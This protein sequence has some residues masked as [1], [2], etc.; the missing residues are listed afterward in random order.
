MWT[1]CENHYQVTCS[2]VNRRGT[3]FFPWNQGSRWLCPTDT[4]QA[5]WEDLWTCIWGDYW[6]TGGQTNKPYTLRILCLRTKAWVGGQGI[7]PNKYWNYVYKAQ[8]ACQLSKLDHLWLKIEQ[9]QNKPPS[10]TST[11]TPI[12]KSTLNSDKESLEEDSIYTQTLLYVHQESW[13]QQ[14]LKRYGNTISLMD[15][16]YKTTNYKL[17][18]FFLAVETNIGYSVVGE[19]V[20]QSETAYQIAEAQ[21]ILSSWNPEW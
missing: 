20:V 15:A 6:Y 9:W 12:Y 21:S 5:S 14:I 18:L 8:R 4:T 3:P 2:L 11:S 16:T 13:Q 7:L 19:F 17:A 1:A 10:L